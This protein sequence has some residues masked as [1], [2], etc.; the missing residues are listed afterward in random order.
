MTQL[1][2]MTADQTGSN[3]APAASAAA[4]RV[5]SS[6]LPDTTTTI[7]QVYATAN[8]VLPKH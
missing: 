6:R 8:Q 5:L 3:S 1:W 2:G 7:V 4:A